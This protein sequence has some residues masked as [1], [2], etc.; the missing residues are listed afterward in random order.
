MQPA[1]HGFIGAYTRDGY[2]LFDPQSMIGDG[3][4]HRITIRGGSRGVRGACLKAIARRIQD[5]E[6][7]VDTMHSALDPDTPQC[8]VCP[9]AGLL[10]ISDDSNDRMFDPMMEIG[11]DALIDL[12]DALLTERSGVASDSFDTTIDTLKAEAVAFERR[13]ARCLESAAPLRLDA[14]EE[15]KSVLNEK[16]LDNMLAP[17]IDTIS[18][19]RAPSETGAESRFFAES[20][21][22]AGVVRYLDTIAYPRVWRLSGPWGCDFHTPLTKL[23]DAALSR[24]LNVM[25]AMDALCPD[26]ISHLLIIEL[27]LFITTEENACAIAYAAQRTID[28]R[29]AMPAHE[30]MPQH[31]MRALAFDELT[32][33]Q[34][35]GRASYNLSLADKVY[36][37]LD[38]R[39]EDRID[40][41]ALGISAIYRRTWTC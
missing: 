32:Y 7:E 37:K 24:G 8:I 28:M 21:T 13:A 31:T 30:L 22:S 27:E 12:D 2:V 26:R 3:S 25:C 40:E 10:A 1:K 39:I 11:G 17:W 4:V 5:R 15:Y 35:I 38:K 34:L 16:L 41:R 20:I 14:E 19:F 6:Y 33:D 29:Q 18:A 9:S 23:R 36:A